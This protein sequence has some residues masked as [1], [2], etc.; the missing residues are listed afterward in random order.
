M[1]QLVAGG[2]LVLGVIFL[3][4]VFFVVRS[5]PTIQANTNGPQP[6]S[7]D[8]DTEQED[9][10][11][12]DAPD[13]SI[14]P[15]EGPPSLNESAAP[16]VDTSMSS[17]EWHPLANEQLYELVNELRSMRSQTQ[18]LEQRLSTLIDMV[19]PVDQANGNIPSKRVVKVE[20]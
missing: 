2:L 20:G 11:T 18:E 16:V 15:I 10:K 13:T 12:P 5:E 14:F 7:A 17:S 9:I 1:S 6:A 19:Q 3:V 8:T 4:A